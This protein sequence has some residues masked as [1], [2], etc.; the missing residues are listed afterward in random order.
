VSRRVH[1]V[2]VGNDFLRDR[3]NQLENHTANRVWLAA[4]TR[5]LAGSR[6]RVQEMG[7]DQPS[8]QHLDT[9]AFMRALDLPSGHAGWAAAWD[10]EPTEQFIEVLASR[11]EGIDL[12]VGF[13]LPDVVVYALQAL[14]IRFMDFEI[15]SLRFARNLIT[16]GRT[17]MHGLTECPAWRMPLWAFDAAAVDYVGWASRCCPDTIPATAGA[18]GVIF[19]QTEIDAALLHS[20][21]IAEY[22]GF[23]PEVRHW[24][25]GL[26]HVLFRP[27]PYA[28]V[29]DAFEQLSE[30]VPQIR[31][32]LMN[33]YQL[34]AS[35]RLARVLALSSGIN[36]E[37]AFFNTPA[38]R[39]FM[40][41]RR[42]TAFHY[43][44]A[45]NL[46]LL[47]GDV[48]EA[49]LEGASPPPAAILEIDLRKQFRLTWG[50]TDVPVPSDF[51]N[52][53]TLEGTCRITESGGG[54]PQA[55]PEPEPHQ[56]AA[57]HPQQQSQTDLHQHSPHQH[58]PKLRHRLRRLARRVA[59]FVLP[60]SRSADP[61][62]PAAAT[63]GTPGPN[64]KDFACGIVEP[65]TRHDSAALP[66][67]VEPRGTSRAA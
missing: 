3:A 46:S 23:G 44:I 63:A 28:T 54:P 25:E 36:D 18:V 22:S 47:G 65:Q 19:G 7:S 39:L 50:L 5:H 12:V 2:A 15:S 9:D 64:P 45:T 10:S 21:R 16:D 14:D 13:G 57:H 60:G 43:S 53:P 6:F 37:A 58:K 42:M 56:P 51:H 49:V 48:L 38:T 20:G 35:Q 24:A 29:P 11:M 27:H 17:N 55:A 30:I 8:A 1:T 26:D 34:L 41:K 33:S 52:P 66:A 59:S 40:P 31:P 67:P 32:T 4:I 62:M 61:A